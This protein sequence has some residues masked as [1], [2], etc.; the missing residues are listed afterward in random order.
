MLDKLRQIAARFDEIARELEHPEVF[1]DPV[2][3]RN[4]MRE[5]GRLHRTVET[6]RTYETVL[7]EKEDARSMAAEGG[8]LADLARSELKELGA[9]E[10]EL[11]AELRRL[12]VDDDPNASKDVIVEIRAGV[13]GDEATLFVSDLFRMYSRWSDARHSK[14]EVLTT[15][16]SEVGGLK[17]IIFGLSGEGSYDRLR[18]ES[19]GHRIQRVPATE[20][21]GRVHTSMATV[22]VLPEAEAIEVDVRDE[23]IKMDTFRAGGP[24]GQ[25]VNKTSS[26]VRLT[27]V[28]SGIVVS[29][30]DESSQHKN[31]AKAM[32]VLRA[33]IFEIEENKRQAERD[34]VRKTQVGTGDRGERIRTYNVPQNRVT[35]HRVKENYNLE[36]VLEGHIDPVLDDLK[37]LDIE[38]KLKTML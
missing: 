15:S 34:E 5:R 8:D 36:R 33:R 24:G 32:R 18:Y 17:E 14:I 27:H 3:S 13:G 2:R 37:R 4:L 25:N 1:G 23:D 7:R 28:P 9:R 11:Y 12:L 30:Q 22:A 31:R 20:S 16:E 19:G 29:C 26:A 21:Q 6:F 38:E 10:T 35:D